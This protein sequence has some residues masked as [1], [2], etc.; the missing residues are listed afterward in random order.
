MIQ[1]SESRQATQS[2]AGMES[3]CRSEH[4]ELLQRILKNPRLPSIPT[5]ALQIIEKTGD[6]E[7]SVDEVGDLIARDPGLCARS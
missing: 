7:C 1:H 3:A 6:L 2:Q 4:D 5:L